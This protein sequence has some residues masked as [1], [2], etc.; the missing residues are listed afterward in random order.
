MRCVAFAVLMLVVAAQAS[1]DRRTPAD[2]RLHLAGLGVIRHRPDPAFPEEGRYV[3]VG[4]RRLYGCHYRGDSLSLPPA[5]R[6]AARRAAHFAEYEVE[7]DRLRCRLL[8][9]WTTAPIPGLAAPGPGE[10]TDSVTWTTAFP[11][12]PAGAPPASGRP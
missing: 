4:E 7:E 2:G 6:R 9:A 3:L 10:R 11:P 8:L 1:C 12:T 5:A